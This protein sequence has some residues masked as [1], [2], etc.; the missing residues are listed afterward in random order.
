M[1]PRS[2]W[3]HIFLSS[4][5]FIVLMC[6][7]FEQ[8]RA[9]GDFSCEN[10]CTGLFLAVGIVATVA[11][12]FGIYA[13]A[14]NVETALAKAP[15]ATEATRP[16]KESSKSVKPRSRWTTYVSYGIGGLMVLGGLDPIRS[17][18]ERQGDLGRSMSLLALG[19][20]IIYVTYLADT[21][22]DPV[23]AVS[24]GPAIYASEA[25]ES[26]PGLTLQGRF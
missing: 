21:K 10:T 18:S 26:L 22:A 23:P 20:G 9:T 12:G 4:A 13:V 8:A 14:S 25:G 15:E 16:S 11:I 1:S 3:K 2:P 7:P 6:A 17:D 19:S 24:L 5:I